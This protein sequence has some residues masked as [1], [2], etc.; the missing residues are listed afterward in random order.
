M[1]VRTAAVTLLSIIC[2][3]ESYGDTVV[4]AAKGKSQ[5]VQTFDG[6][7][8]SSDGTTFLFTQAGSATPPISWSANDNE[9]VIYLG[10]P[11]MQ[12]PVNPGHIYFSID[13]ATKDTDLQQ[14]EIQKA[15]A[16]AASDPGGSARG[17]PQE[18]DLRQCTVRGVDQIIERD[19]YGGN[20]TKTPVQGTLQRIGNGFAELKRKTDGVTVKYR[21][22][23]LS[24][25][26]VG[27]CQ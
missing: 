14:A 19:P 16:K 13:Q 12:A 27:T 5:P 3:G 9:I 25:I 11:I 26:A 20:S 23:D 7:V 1:F 4:K 24:Q 10:T 8:S 2:A 17:V 15:R 18:L 21:L 6:Q 22:D